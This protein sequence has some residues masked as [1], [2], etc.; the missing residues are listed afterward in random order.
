M[1]GEEPKPL[2][3]S[4]CLTSLPEEEIAVPLRGPEKAKDLAVQL[5][6]FLAEDDAPMVID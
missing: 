3:I 5:M 2:T 1:A 4:K 6:S